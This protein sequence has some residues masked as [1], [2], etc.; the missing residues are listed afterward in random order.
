M[1]EID[2]TRAYSIRT[3]TGIKDYIIMGDGI[4]EIL[5]SKNNIFSQLTIR[6]QI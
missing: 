6:I 1:Q 5:D 2:K 3:K 4:S